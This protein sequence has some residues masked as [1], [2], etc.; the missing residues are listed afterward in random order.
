MICLICA[1]PS[2]GKLCT[3]CNKIYLIDRKYKFIRNRK[4]N[5]SQKEHSSE[6]LLYR[7][8]CKIFGK[9]NIFRH[10]HP[11]WAISKKNVLLEYDVAI[12]SEK[13]LIEYD[14]RQHF[15]FPNYFHKTRKEFLKQKARDKLKSELAKENN[16][17]LVR[18]NYKDKIDDINIE[19]KLK[20]C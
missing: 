19:R 17:K 20:L 10:V 2:F 1:Q 18:F 4:L 13:L 12:P 8:L 9:K 16:W 7:N 15:E 11:L 3:E 5:C 6:L 14:G